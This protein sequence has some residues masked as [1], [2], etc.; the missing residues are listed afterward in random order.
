MNRTLSSPKGSDTLEIIASGGLPA[1]GLVTREQRE[2]AK[3]MPP[4]PPP[5]DG[6]QSGITPRAVGL[7]KVAGKQMKKGSS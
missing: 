5:G 2:K 3:G 1:L 4:P 6:G 7:A